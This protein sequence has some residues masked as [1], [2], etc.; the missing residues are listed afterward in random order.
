MK[1]DLR[2]ARLAG[3]EIRLHYSWFPVSILV[4]VSMHAL[5]SDLLPFSDRPLLVGL[6]MGASL[7]FF[8]SLLAHEMAHA[9]VAIRRGVGVHS[10]TLFIFGGVARILGEP[11]T[12]R[13]EFLITAAGP[14]M[15]LA[16][17][18]LLIG[19]GALAEALGILEIAA[20]AILVGEVNLILAA[21]NLLPGFPLDGGRV[22]RA[23]VWKVT[24][25][26]VKATRIA[27][28]SGQV[29]AALIAGAGIYRI[30]IDGAIFGGVWLLLISTFLAQAAA[31]SLR[32]PVLIQTAE[33]E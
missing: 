22:L 27:A 17:G 19:F 1:A 16:I 18:G 11:K 31:A 29:V 20:L 26:V 6:A 25:D 10:I 24:G 33:V 28:R 9:L 7:L 5:F 30:M 21:F 13:D 3:I 23:I 14:G 4:G 12:P 32:L 2:I 15:S 8:G